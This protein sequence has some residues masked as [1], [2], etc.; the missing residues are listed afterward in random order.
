[1][2]NAS[3]QN[4]AQTM[5]ELSPTEQRLGRFV[6]EHT[7]EVPFLSTAELSERTGVSTASVTRFAQRLGYEGYPHLQREIRAYLR[8]AFAPKVAPEAGPLET[9]WQTEAANLELVRQV[10]QAALETAAEALA[11]A[12]RVWVVA[13]RATQYVA[14]YGCYDLL[15]CRSD[16]NFV[17]SEHIGS[18]E[19]SVDVEATDVLLVYTIRRYTKATTRLVEL[20]KR[21]NPRVILIT[22]DGHPPVAR[23]ADQ[24]IRV[25][26]LNGSGLRSLASLTSLTHALILLTSQRCGGNR[27]EQ[28]EA[29]IHEADYYEY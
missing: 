16:V 9:F 8:S 2:S 20:W 15:T 3:W 10:P 5:T 28:L 1:M 4:L 12:R 25:P 26:I 22:D 11:A 21:R 29:I 13:G 23:L 27:F 24:V 19:L 14:Q 17:L 7:D 18:I 6:L